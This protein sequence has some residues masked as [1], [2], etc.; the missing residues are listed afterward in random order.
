MTARVQIVVEAQDASSGI[1]RAI[2]GQ[3][4]SL[5]PLVEELTAKNVNWG[6]VT[7]QAANL[8]IEGLKDSVKATIEYAGQVRQL[9]TI[10]GQSTEETSRFIQVLDDYG[11]SADDALIATKAL[12]KQGYAPSIETLAKLSDQYLAINNAEDRNAFIL[13]NL[14][15]GGLRWVEVLGEGSKALLEH[16]EAI[17]KNLLLSQDMVDAARKNEIA[18]DNWND[19][20]MGIKITLGNALLPALTE[21]LNALG[22][23]SREYEILA[24]QGLNVTTATAKQRQAALEQAQAEREAATAA[25]LHKDAMVQEGQSAED[26]AAATKKLTDHYNSLISSIMN[27]QQ[28]TDR[29]TQ[30]EKDL[31]GQQADIQVKIAE[32][33]KTYGANSKQV[34]EEGDKLIELNGKLAEN[35]KQHQKWAAQ[36]VFSFAQARAAA[37]G[38]ITEGE[39]QV[40]IAIGEQLG[41]FDEK[42]ADT[43]ESVN[44][45]FDDL[46]TSNAQDTVAALKT[47]LQQLTGQDWIINIATNTSGV[48]IPSGGGTPRRAAGGTVYAGNPYMVG[49]TGTEPFV[50]AQ[51][52]RILG[53]AESLHAMSLSGAGQTNYFYGPVAL[54]VGEESGAGL[55]EIR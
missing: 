5:G 46:D 24:Q 22:D 45:A 1:L 20:L 10:S 35:A 48:N 19:A 7:Q 42:T 2:A 53:H 39:G 50:P 15:K 31:L 17:R 47:S 34:A 51:N 8:V 4:G 14:G 52:G 9:S 44:K 29:Y 23:T 3:L 26:V 40:L 49:E 28:E 6:N 16:G 13:K 18:V 37:D 36:T 33:T 25:M 41:L 27:A 54:T 55:L 38:S 11:V 43:M 30:T 32:L 21:T 12:T